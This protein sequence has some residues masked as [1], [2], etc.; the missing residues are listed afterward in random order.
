MGQV[1]VDEETGECLGHPFLDGDIRRFLNS[2]NN[3][4]TGEPEVSIVQPRTVKGRRIPFQIPKDVKDSLSSKKGPSKK[5]K[6]LM[7]V[8][9]VPVGSSF[10]QINPVCLFLPAIVYFRWFLALLMIFEVVLH[11]WAHHK[12]KS[13][14]NSTF[15]FRS[16]FHAIS[17]EFCALCQNEMCMDRV[18]KMQEIRMHK[19]LRQCNYMKRVVT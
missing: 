9:P 8:E 17:S 15:Y 6:N 11:V 2:V 4:E 5:G 3:A 18:G 7:E 13:L 1:F 12:N 16:P 10:G 19:F 14:K